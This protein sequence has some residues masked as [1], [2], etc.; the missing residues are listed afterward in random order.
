MTA[1]VSAYDK[2]MDLHAYLDLGGD[3]PK[4]VERMWHATFTR[5]LREMGFPRRSCRYIWDNLVQ[6]NWLRLWLTEDE[7]R[8]TTESWLDDFRHEVWYCS[9][10]WSLD[11]LTRCHWLYRTWQDSKRNRKKSD[12]SVEGRDA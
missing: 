3:D 6:G 4:K 9:D 8:R 7:K 10:R 11:R 2:A 5:V 12:C 1:S